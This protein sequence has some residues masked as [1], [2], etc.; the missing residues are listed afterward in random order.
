MSMK[1]LLLTALIAYAPVASGADK[2]IQNLQRDVALLQMDMQ[3]FKRSQEDKLA[4][5]TALVQQTL[6]AANKAST[7][8]AV[9]DS[10][11]RQHLKEQEKSVIAPV[12]GVSAKV[13]QLTGEF[14]GLRDFVADV[15]ARLGKL[16]QQI[17]DLSNAV[18]VMQAPALPPPGA[19]GPPPMP[20]ETLYQNALRDRS[21]GKPQLALQQFT[22]Y[23]KYYSDTDLAPNAQYYIGEIHFSQGDLDVAL[24]EFDLVLEKYADNNKTPDALYMKGLTLVKMG[25]R[26]QGAEEFQELAKRFPATFLATKACSQLKEMGLRCPSASTA[27]P[28]R[29][30]TKK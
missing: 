27:A 28:P 10:S 11:I 22:D 21:G 5:L 3:N 19:S 2:D 18:K 24:K 25:K 7:A 9:L 23:L 29:R 14:Q 17:V 4:A 30:S 12:A 1:R 8:S 26:T 6:D 16:Q 20:A 13:D 15:S